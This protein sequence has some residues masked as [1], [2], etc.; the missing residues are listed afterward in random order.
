MANLQGA[1]L[2]T[3]V[4]RNIRRYMPNAYADVYVQDEWR[5]VST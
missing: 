2:F 3:A 1:R 5:P 4:A